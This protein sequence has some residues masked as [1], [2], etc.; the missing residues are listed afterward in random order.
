MLNDWFKKHFSDPQVV[1]LAVGL[2]LIFSGI[3]WFGKTLAPFLTAIVIAYLLNGLVDP[4]ARLRCPRLLATLLVYVLFVFFILLIFLALIPMLSR[5]AGQLFQQLPS[6]LTEG[7]KTL[8]QLPVR[9]PDFISSTQV[10]EMIGMIQQQLGQLGQ[11]V[12]SLSLSSVVGLISILIYVI[13]VPMMVFFLM[14]DR[15]RITD[16]MVK[17]L[18]N[19]NA[20][21][22]QV[23]VQVDIQIGNYVRGKFWE[24]LIVWWT[25]YVAF[26]VMGLPYAMLLS[27]LVGLSVLVPYVG[28]AVV[29][30]PVFAVAWHTWGG[31]SDMVYL[32]SVYLII[33]ALDGTLLVPLLFAE[34]VNLH[35]VAIMLA[36]LFFGGIWGVLGV[37]F[38]I[39]LATLVQAVLVAWPKERVVKTDIVSP[40]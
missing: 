10:Q 12:V 16:W 5:Q 20:L 36:V 13:L 34:V 11:E 27:V 25:D 3:F 30:V 28:A 39:P 15:Q 23:W 22:K 24:V 7:Q 9:Y 29:T 32:M 17:Y 21:A 2:I 38:A 33:Q 26:R 18:P 6:I 37:F 14:K 4:I 19:E 1:Y 35:P 8:M 40:S 31:T